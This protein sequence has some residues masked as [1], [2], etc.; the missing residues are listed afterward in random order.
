MLLEFR[1]NS[2]F[3]PVTTLISG[4]LGP[5]GLVGYS[6]GDLEW[7]HPES[8][9]RGLIGERPG[10]GQP[11]PRNASFA[12]RLTA[13]TKDEMAAELSRLHTG[14][15][16][17]RRRGGL[18]AFRPTGATRTAYLRVLVGGVTIGEWGAQE[19]QVNVVRPLVTFTV[20]PLIE[21]DPMDYT[22]SFDDP[23]SW[24]SDFT[25]VSGSR[26]DYSLLDGGLVANANL[27]T[28]LRV[29]LT[30][31]GYQLPDLEVRAR[32]T[33]RGAQVKGGVLLAVMNNT[34]YIECYADD[35]GSVSRLR[36]DVIINGVRT[37]RASTNVSPRLTSVEQ[38]FDV[39][40][41]REG[42]RIV[43]EL[44][45]R[46]NAYMP[47]HTVTW[48][49]S[50][51][52]RATF[53]RE[54][55]GLAGF[56]VVPRVAGEVMQ[57][58]HARPFTFR[59]PLRRPMI[60][61]G[62]V[63]GDA[64]ARADAW[65]Q[66]V[67]SSFT[68][69]D[70]AWWG[71]LAWTSQPL[72]N[73]GWSANFL[74]GSVELVGGSTSEPYHW[75]TATSSVTVSS[76]YAVTGAYSLQVTVA[77]DSSRGVEARLARHFQARV[78]YTVAYWVR[79]DTNFNMGAALGRSTAGQYEID[80]FTATTTWQRRYITFTPPV[81]LHE[82]FVAW[83]NNG[84]AGTFYL[85]GIKTWEGLPADEPDIAGTSDP[86]WGYIDATHRTTRGANYPG[87]SEPRIS[88]STGSASGFYSHPGP[89]NSPIVPPAGRT[90]TWQVPISPHLMVPSDYSDTV[91]VEVWA[92]WLLSSA[93]DGGITAGI[94][95]V[96]KPSTPWETTVTVRRPLI[97]T[98][99]ELVRLGSVTMR[100]TQAEASNTSLFITFSIGAG[101]N[102]QPSGVEGIYLVDP[103]QRI[104]LPTG[105]RWSEV[106]PF[107]YRASNQQNE[108]W[109]IYRPDL[110]GIEYEDEAYMASRISPT[111][112]PIELPPG[113][114]AVMAA[115]SSKVPNDPDPFFGSQFDRML[116]VAV[117]FAVTP[118]YHT[119]PS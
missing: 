32:F 44:L 8:G 110:T 26:S 107:V 24:Q 54:E 6:L 53:P 49:L 92:R 76:A 16:A 113:R 55:P 105:V 83:R 59:V 15:T 79:S 118:R 81:N 3:D 47:T 104:T 40:A 99:W 18:V 101:T 111:G 84:V 25:V 70:T 50:A 19:D 9:Q 51:S 11:R 90:W 109:S 14:V 112:P 72:R 103:R 77:A 60:A 52:E 68:E 42:D 38:R 33:P 39:R 2:R 80:F 97:A 22:E 1:P 58:W 20:A 17:L 43:C 62:I 48:D 5:W 119:L 27:A 116:P 64:P 35:T 63:P 74:K 82:A 7:D 93:F 4:S 75:L 34:T 98:S 106:G 31:P 88:T 37:N 115:I 117:H 94:A 61:T 71:M 45:K 23:A 57:F 30:G 114:I 100:A 12:L 78:P 28:E 85:D 46:D 29:V 89:Y 13:S 10:T 36:I 69:N 66:N 73:V 96:G 95:G 21:G 87:G 102:N 41:R 86:P 67:S 108:S 56:S 91:E 65:L